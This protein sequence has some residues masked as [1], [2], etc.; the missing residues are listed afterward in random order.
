MANRQLFRAARLL[1]AA[2]AILL[3]Q[4]AAHAGIFTIT[5]GNAESIGDRGGTNFSNSDP[6]SYFGKGL[7]T[8]QGGWANGPGFALDTIFV[9]PETHHGGYHGISG[10]TNNGVD[11]T[12]TLDVARTIRFTWMGSGNAILVN[13]FYVNDGTSNILVFQPT[14]AWVDLNG[15]GTGQVPTVDINLPAGVIHFSWVTGGN[16]PFTVVNGAGNANVNND[17]SFFAGID[18]YLATGTYQRTGDVLYLGLSDSA[19]SPTS[20][21]HDFQDLGVRLEAIGDPLPVPPVPEPATLTTFLIGLA[22]SGGWAGVRK[23]RNPR[24]SSADNH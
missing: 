7:P 24:R 16:T 15:S 18:P 20:G 13:S 12:V 6:L 21:D 19:G 22:V 9:D 11:M 2:L 4:S 14:M 17:P 1:L 3:G 5:G 23:L 8:E 10:Y